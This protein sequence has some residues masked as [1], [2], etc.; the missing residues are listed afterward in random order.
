MLNADARAALTQLVQRYHASLTKKRADLV[1]AHQAAV[2]DD[3]SEEG[4]AAFKLL[5]HRMAGSAASYGFTELGD[6]ARMLDQVLQFREHG[7]APDHVGDYFDRLLRDLD[8][9]IRRPPPGDPH[10][11]QGRHEDEHR[12]TEMPRVVLVDDD[13]AMVD[14][15]SRQLMAVGFDVSGFTDPFASME[16]V[17]KIRPA[18]ILMDLMFTEGEDYGFQIAEAMVARL[19]YK[20]GLVYLS[21][22]TDVRARQ[23][24]VDSGADAFFTKPV[25][26]TALAQLLEQF[27]G[28]G[29][30]A[31]VENGRVAIVEDDQQIGQYYATLLEGSGFRT[32]LISE[33]VTALERLLDFRPDLVLMDMQMPDLDGIEL[34]QILRHHESLFDIPVLFLTSVTDPGLLRGALRAGADALLSKGDDPELILSVVQRRIQRFRRVTYTLTRDPLTRL[35]NRPALME[36]VSFELQRAQREGQA[37]YMAV[38]DIDGFRQFNETHGRTAGDQVL[39]E[40]TEGVRSRLRQVDVIGRYGGD[41][42]MIIMPSTRLCSGDAVMQELTSRVSETPIELGDK[43]FD[44]TI[45]TAVIECQLTRHDSSHSV[46]QQA[47][48]QLEALLKTAGP[49]QVRSGELSTSATNELLHGGGQRQLA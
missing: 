43:R 19:R 23:W 35:Y 7:T 40:I 8:G 5:V 44:I 11:E 1:A 41:E 33:P 37:F 12:L 9:C 10:A 16:A 26:V 30:Q 21:Q 3:W 27:S 46:L 36:R 2:E 45:S 4:T 28:R 39:R 32:A 13:P 47:L 15:L 14:I 17:T 24:A 48:S 29:E 6:A 22:R 31:Y 34:T 42:I 20:P 18:V 49:G 25:N 38:F